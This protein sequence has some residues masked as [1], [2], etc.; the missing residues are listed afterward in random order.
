MTVKRLI[1]AVLQI[2]VHFL[3]IEP[4]EEQ[5]ASVAK[6]KERL[7]VLIDEVSP[8]WAD[9]EF[10]V[11]DGMRRRS[12]RRGGIGANGS[13]HRCR[14][15][16]RCPEPDGESGCF[17]GVSNMPKCCHGFQVCYTLK[18]FSSFTFSPPH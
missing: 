3:T 18:G 1:G 11:L 8:V 12:V 15:R 10:E 6:I 5:P 7:A 16:K 2:L 14:Q 17:H 13:Q 4:L 9:L